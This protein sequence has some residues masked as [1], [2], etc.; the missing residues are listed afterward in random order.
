MLSSK[1]N[2]YLLIHGLIPSLFTALIV[3]SGFRM[4]AYRLIAVSSAW[5]RAIA[6][7][8][9]GNGLVAPFVMRRIIHISGWPAYGRIALRVPVGLNPPGRRIQPKP[10]LTGFTW[11]L[12]S[13]R[14]R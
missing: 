5:S 12:A 10:P 14:R 3:G 11:R 1:D 13:T 8:L 2:Q 9:A 6:W 4:T 7:L